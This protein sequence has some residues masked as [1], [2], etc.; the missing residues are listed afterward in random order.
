[1]H[2][3]KKPT[4][5]LVVAALALVAPRMAAAA[6]TGL[7][8][9][10]FRLQQSSYSPTIAALDKVLP[11]AKFPD[12][13]GSANRT[14]KPCAA[15]APAVVEAF[16][17]Q[18]TPGADDQNGTDWYPQ[19]ITSSADA[20]PSGAYQAQTVLAA[21]WYWHAG[22][23]DR[24]DRI[25]F[26]DYSDPAHPV[27][28]L[29]LLVLPTTSSAGKPDFKPLTNS[30]GDAVHGGGMFWYGNYIYVVDTTG[31]LRV[32]DLDHL[33]SVDTGGDGIGLQSDGS[34]QAF[35]YK[36]VLPQAFT[37]NTSTAGGYPAFRFSSTA[38][39]RT[40]GSDTMVISEYNTQATD[41]HRIVRYPLNAA[42]HTLAASADGL[43]H[44][45]EAYET[46][47]LKTQGTASVRGRYYA[48]TSYS[49]SGAHYGSLYSYT[50]RQSVAKYENVLQ[51]Y[52]EDLSYWPGRD[53]LWSLS[54][55][56]GSRVVYAM[57][58][59]L[60]AWPLVQNGG[61][62]TDVKALQYL[63]N[64]QHNAGLTVDGD[65]GPATL[66]AVK[67]FQTAHGLTADGAVGP[68]TWSALVPTVNAGSTGDA[69][70]AV[71]AELTAHGW[72]TTIS[73]TL[74][75]ATV[76]SLKAFQTA[77]GLAAD[78]VVGRDTWRDLI[79]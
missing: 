3:W 68:N 65:F 14:A 25:A 69:V 6:P 38:L 63:L 17:W 73:G 74:D 18:S 29:V 1:M 53:E 59:S 76:T 13:I 41:N 32:F 51:P 39:D 8:P 9:A 33:W 67:S 12:V 58:E 5:I 21:G 2:Y 16:C 35:G 77:N 26:V 43:V 47:I 23:V 48:S 45:I 27:Y 61:T 72:A 30:S 4:A 24:G 78:S 20:D 15:H 57:R 44:G 40:G 54:E 64:S 28:R 7:T 36:Y 37:Y 79:N 50:A 34:Y 42:D 19:G 22:G 31:G 55:D 10:N 75:A 46:G 70:R 56:P 62:G 66:A 49:T 60:L 11:T 71:Q 52:P